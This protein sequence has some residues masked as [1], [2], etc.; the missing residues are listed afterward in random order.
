[1]IPTCL[2]K[3]LSLVDSSPFLEQ[4]VFTGEGLLKQIKKKHALLHF[5]QAVYSI[6]RYTLS[7]A[8]TTLTQYIWVDSGRVSH[9]G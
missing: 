9:D 1:M 2:P 7:N 5:P 8:V 6:E 4:M 3:I